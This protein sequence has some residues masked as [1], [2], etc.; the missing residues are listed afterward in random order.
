VAVPSLKE[1]QG[2]WSTLRPEKLVQKGCPVKPTEITEGD[3]NDVTGTREKNQGNDIQ[4]G[5]QKGEG[6]LKADECRRKRGSS[7]SQRWKAS[8]ANMERCIM[9]EKRLAKEK[10]K[11]VYLENRISNRQRG[12]ERQ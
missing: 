2:R 10:K 1:K 6:S 12:K 8:A 11:K 3:C 4:Q 9:V 7:T 5:V